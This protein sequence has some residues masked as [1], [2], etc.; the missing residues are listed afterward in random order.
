LEQEEGKW[1]WYTEVLVQDLVIGLGFDTLVLVEWVCGLKVEAM[2]ND[3]NG[4]G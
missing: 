4:M 3:G 2:E 1:R